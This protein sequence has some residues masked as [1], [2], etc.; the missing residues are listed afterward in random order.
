MHCYAQ[1]PDEATRGVA[2][3]QAWSEPDPMIGSFES[4]IIDCPDPRAFVRFYSKILFYSELFSP[5][6]FSGRRSSAAI[7]IRRNLSHPVTPARFSH[8]S[9]WTT[10]TPRG[11]RLRTCPSRCISMS[12]SM[13]LMSPRPLPWRWVR[14]R[15]GQL[16]RR[17]GSISTRPGIRSASLDPRTDERSSS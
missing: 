8:F 2:Q 15:R 13:N 1:V 14:R 9:A 4:I 6:S 10:T 17:L 7:T 12:R 11:G 5:P 16:R 3:R